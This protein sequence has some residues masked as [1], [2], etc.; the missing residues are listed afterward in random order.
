MFECL[1]MGVLDITLGIIA[2]VFVVPYI[3]G[4]IVQSILNFGCLTARD[5][6]YSNNMSCGM[7]VLAL[8]A[9]FLVASSGIYA[10]VYLVKYGSWF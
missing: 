8:L 3:I 1:D 7:L 10:V 4:H 6:S 5:Y 2:G 9:V